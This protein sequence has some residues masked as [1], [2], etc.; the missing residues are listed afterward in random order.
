MISL[1]TMIIKRNAG[2]S[3]K[4]TQK[5]CSS[6]IA[7]ALPYYRPSMDICIFRTSH[8]DVGRMYPITLRSFWKNISGHFVRFPCNHSLCT[9]STVVGQCMEQRSGVP[10]GYAL[11]TGVLP[12]TLRARFAHVKLFLQFYRRIV[13]TTAMDG[14]SVDFASLHGCNLFGQCRSYCRGASHR[15]DALTDFIKHVPHCLR[16]YEISGLGL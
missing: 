9:G 15:P 1:N 4:C 7:P 5:D 3:E 13:Q 8:V 2:I 14:G 10:N 11:I 16:S 12:V 6:A